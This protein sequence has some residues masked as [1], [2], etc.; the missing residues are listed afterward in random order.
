MS[1]RGDHN[2]R[3]TSGQGASNQSN[4]AFIADDQNQPKSNH[5]KGDKITGGEPSKKQEA[6][7]DQS[8]NR[9]HSTEGQTE[10]YK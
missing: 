2:K 9:D 3:G 7:E 4:E 8:A 1:G 6:S 5:N 10:K